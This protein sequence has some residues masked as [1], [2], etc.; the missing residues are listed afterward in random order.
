MSHHTWHSGWWD[1]ARS[2]PSPNFGERPPDVPIDL[3]VIHSISLPPGQFGGPE[4]EQLFT[5]TLDWDAHPYF[6]QIRGA[7][8]SA[9]FLIRRDGE[10]VQFVSCDQRAWHAGISVWAGRSNC[11]DYSVG[12]EF[13]GL[14]GGLFEAAQYAAAARLITA[15][16]QQ[17]PIAQIVGHQHIAPN[18]KRDPGAGFD[19]AGLAQ[20]LAW[21]A[22]SIPAMLGAPQPEAPHET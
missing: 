18:R 8:V 16:A 5:N 9:H 4:I 20:R 11:N 13:E 22:A 2:V 12:I 7:E 17:Y 3:V 6:D 21:P 1:A 14:E 10:V 19:W 15:L